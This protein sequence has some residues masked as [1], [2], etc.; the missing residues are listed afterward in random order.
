MTKNEFIEDLSQTWNYGVYSALLN[1][2][3]WSFSRRPLR[4]P[5]FQISVIERAFSSTVCVLAA[6]QIESILQNKS[7][8]QS[9]DDTDRD[10]ILRL[11][12]NR[13]L[14]QAIREL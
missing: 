10:G 14:N 7:Y 2:A 5:A 4:G 12:T 8:E 11:V 9:N 1:K 6:F 13:Q 3:C